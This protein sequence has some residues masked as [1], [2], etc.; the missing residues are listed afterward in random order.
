MTQRITTMPK[1]IRLTVF[2][3]FTLC[4]MAQAQI[5]V[6]KKS[7]AAVQDIQAIKQQ[8]EWTEIHPGVWR[9][10]VGKPEAYDLLRAAGATPRD[11]KKHTSELQ[12]LMRT[13]YAV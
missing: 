9:A 11:R 2:L 12:S 1:L 6:L 13:P 7:G 10:V 3:L 4:H 5:P 8:P